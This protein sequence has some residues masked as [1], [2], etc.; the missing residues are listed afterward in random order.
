M[1]ISLI[2]NFIAKQ[3]MKKS[4]GITSVIPDAK[5]LHLLPII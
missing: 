5:K 3:M 1:A 2:R 4:K